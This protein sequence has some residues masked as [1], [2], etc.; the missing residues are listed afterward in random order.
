MGGVQFA[1]L[2]VI[3]MRRRGL[4]AGFQVPGTAEGSQDIPV[5]RVRTKG[6]GNRNHQA[7]DTSQPFVS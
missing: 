5:C 4:L 6:D 7:R 2:M 3:I 1:V